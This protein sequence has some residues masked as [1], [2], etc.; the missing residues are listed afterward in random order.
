MGV[1]CWRGSSTLEIL[2]AFAVLTLALTAV[3][4]VFSANQDIAVDTQTASEALGLA[5]AEL[6]TARAASRADFALVNPTVSTTTS[7]IDYVKTLAVGQV[8]FFTKQ[9]TSTVSWNTGGRTL[10]VLLSTI[11]TNPSAIHGGD[12]CSSVLEGDWTNPTMKTYEFGA[13]ILGDTSSGFPISSIQT[14]NG[15][16]YAT[17]DNDNG[18][19]DE[20][21]FVLDISNPS[22]ILSGTVPAVLDK[23]DNASSTYDVSRGLNGVAVD[24]AGHAYAANAHDANFYN[25]GEADNCAQMQVFNVVD[26]TNIS[27]VRNFKL[28]TSS[29]PYVYAGGGSEQAVG[30]SIAYADKY[31]YLGLSTTV[32]G[33]GFHIIDVSDPLNPVHVSSWPTPAPSFGPS[34]APINAIW[35]RDNYAYIAHP[36]GLVGAE[37][38]ELTVLDISNPANPVR[39]S[40]F[41]GADNGIG[42][43]GKSLYVVGSTIYFGRTASKISGNSSDAFPELFILDAT[44]PENLP[45]IPKG[46]KSLD[47]LPTGPGEE[48]LNGLIVRDYLAFL[49][50]NSKLQILQIDNPSNITSYALDLTLE[51]GTGG[52]QQ[53]S[54]S[55]CEGNYLFIGSESSDDKG[56]LSVISGS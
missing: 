51:P 35:V 38:E 39:V 11:F 7:G 30:K 41:D 4:L 16:L 55:D 13:D 25:C 27:H 54:A 49:I 18:N 9:A 3:I 19:N 46:S 31:V 32:N 52:G 37:N 50:E 40:G 28:A 5:Q 34:G 22:A 44:D 1:L 6:E 56:Y 53:G 23:F 20:T 26:P 48:S 42:A 8:D 17:V 10:S 47:P 15:K 43:N 21:F 33:P 29:A 2:I 14:F 36:E 12:T 24:G 45:S